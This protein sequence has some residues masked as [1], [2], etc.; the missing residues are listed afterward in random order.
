MLGEQ[1]RWDD[2]ACSQKTERDVKRTR[3]PTPHDLILTYEGLES[4]HGESRFIEGW[5]GQARSWFCWNE[6]RMPGL[7]PGYCQPSPSTG[8][9]Q[10]R[11]IISNGGFR[12]RAKAPI[13]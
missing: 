6:E 3:S 10:A 7:H 8:S 13:A 2:Q 4:L 9:G 1:A 11:R 5:M 12:G